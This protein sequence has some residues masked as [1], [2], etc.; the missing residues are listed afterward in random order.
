MLNGGFKTYHGSCSNYS[1]PSWVSPVLGWCFEGLAEG[2][3]HGKT[4]R[5][6]CG[7]NPG[8]M[9]YESNSIG[10]PLSH[11]GRFIYTGTKKIGHKN[12]L[13]LY[14]TI[15]TFN[16]PNPFQ[17]KPWFLCACSRSL[18]KTLWE[19]EKLLVTS[20]FSFSHSVF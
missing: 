17:D 15:L 11:A 1:C 16:D 20:K 12:I 2:H 9:D 6:L 10:L 18:L 3:S 7:S 4:Q 19:K 13:Y 5:I 14:H 8:P